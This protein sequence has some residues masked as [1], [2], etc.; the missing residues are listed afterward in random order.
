MSVKGTVLA[1]E[2][3][4]LSFENMY[5]KFMLSICACL[6]VCMPGPLQE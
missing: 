6:F 1:A 2:W 5:F 3:A 4:L